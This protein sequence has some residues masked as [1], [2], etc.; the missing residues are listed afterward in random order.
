MYN[1]DPHVVSGVPLNILEHIK[2]TVAS[3]GFPVHGL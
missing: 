1:I 3:L 2:T